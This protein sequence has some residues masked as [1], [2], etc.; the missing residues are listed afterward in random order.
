MAKLGKL[1]FLTALAGAAAAGIAYLTKCNAFENETEDD[2]EDEDMD[3]TVGPE[4]EDDFVDEDHAND[5][6]TYIALKADKN[7]FL[8]AAGDMLSAAK[9]AAGAV[10]NMAVDA[11]G[12]V[13][14]SSFDAAAVAKDAAA[15]A[16]DKAAVVKSK[17]VSAIHNL[18]ASAK[19][20]DLKEAAENAVDAVAGAAEEVAESAKDA[21]EAVK[22][23]V[24]DD[25][26][27]ITEDDGE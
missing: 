10:K 12:I 22:K 18:R 5:D 7:E 4:D 16:K 24:K 25:A 1:V 17:A 11:A 14:D 27:V 6:R 9:D 23:A 8:A 2:F 3:E 15:T 21:A 19:D 13:T 26:P 20:G